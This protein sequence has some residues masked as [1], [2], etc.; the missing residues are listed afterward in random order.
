MLFIL[1]SSMS[2]FILHNC[3]TMT[4]M[5]VT[6]VTVTHDVISHFCLSPKIKKSKI[7][8]KIRK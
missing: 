1:E 2:F 6:C 5:Y 4:M 7:K 8:K 3:V